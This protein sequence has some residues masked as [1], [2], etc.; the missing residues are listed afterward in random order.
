MQAQLPTA[1]PFMLP[2]QQRDPA[3]SLNQPRPFRSILQFIIASP[4]IRGCRIPLKLLQLFSPR[5]FCTPCY[6]ELLAVCFGETCPHTCPERLPVY[7]HKH[8]DSPGD[9]CQLWWTT[10][11]PI[12]LLEPPTLVKHHELSQLSAVEIQAWI[13]QPAPFKKTPTNNKPCVYQ[14][15]S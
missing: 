8:K 15:P 11:L 9:I 13:M 14:S 10:T 2:K 6:E 12:L 5:F 4:Q 3:S 1:G 7:G